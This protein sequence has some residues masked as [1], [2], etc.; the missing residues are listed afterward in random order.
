MSYYRWHYIG[1]LIFGL[2]LIFS[3]FIVPREHGFNAI[4]ILTALFAIYDFLIMFMAKRRGNNNSK[5]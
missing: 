2:T 4:I 1:W 5:P 3:Y